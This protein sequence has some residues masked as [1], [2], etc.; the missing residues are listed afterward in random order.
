MFAFSVKLAGIP[1]ELVCRYEA[2]RDF[3]KSYL[4]DEAPLFSL[5]TD[6]ALIDSWVEAHVSNRKLQGRE[7]NPDFGAVVENF[8]FFCSISNKLLDYD[9]LTVHGSSL[10][11]DGKGYF[12]TAAS[13]TGKSTHAS[14]WRQVFGDRCV[15]IND[16]K[17][18]VRSIDGVPY[19]FGSPFAGKHE[20]HTNTCAPLE[21]IAQIVRSDVNYVTPCPISEAFPL[22]TTQLFVTL[23][24]ES[25][26][27]AIAL[28]TDLL[29]NVPFFKLHCNME[30]SAALAAYE[31]LT[32]G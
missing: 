24:K 20:L 15:M 12:F 14:L 26:K 5:T 27:K 9:V 10:S 22:M 13:G 28:S 31:G 7:P 18:I 21:A 30:P 32:R 3:F 16:D 19:I 11:L 17:P 6:E 4:T 25:L 29:K 8:L 1:F 23:G 2:L